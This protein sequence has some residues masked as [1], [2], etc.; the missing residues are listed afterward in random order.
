MTRSP[1]GYGSL[2]RPVTKI[3]K[4]TWLILFQRGAG[5]AEDP[6]KVSGWFEHTPCRGIWLLPSISGLPS[7]RGGVEKDE[8]QAALWRRHATQGLPDAQ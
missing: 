5:A 3:R 6:L 4:R 1:G 2:Q 8:Q 7:Q